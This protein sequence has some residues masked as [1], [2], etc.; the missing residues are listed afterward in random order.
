[1]YVGEELLLR[2]IGSETGR[3]ED[4]KKTQSLMGE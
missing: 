2:G 4:T 3:K 1:M